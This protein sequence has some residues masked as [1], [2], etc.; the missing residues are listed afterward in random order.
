MDVVSAY[1]LGELEEDAYLEVLE[2]LDL[3]QGKVLKAVKGLPGLKQS[4]RTWNRKITA[5]FE[6]HSLQN[7]PADHSVSVNKERTLIV[8]LYVDDLL[9][10]APTVDRIQ[11]LKQALSEAFEMK[12]LGESKFVLSISIIRDHTAKTITI[13]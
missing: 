11:P 8:A 4:G 12:D 7:L 5:F 9:L 10:F 1:L 6:E 13:D 3:P 2:G